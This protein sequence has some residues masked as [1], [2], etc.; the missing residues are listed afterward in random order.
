MFYGKQKRF[1]QHVLQMQY[2]SLLPKYNNK[3][4]RDV[5]YNNKKSRDVSSVHTG[6]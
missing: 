1:M 5:K 4:S 6:H 3:K 2:I